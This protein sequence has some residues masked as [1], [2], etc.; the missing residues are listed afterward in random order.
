MPWLIGL[1]S[2]GYQIYQAEHAKSQAKKERQQAEESERGLE[3]SLNN[4]PKYRPN[5][6]ILNYY[7]E[8]LRKYNVAPTSTSEY[9]AEQQ[10]INRNAGSALRNLQ[11]RRSALAGVPSVM[12]V[13]NNAL[14][15]AA[16]KAEQ[17][18]EQQLNRVGQ[19][20]QMKASEE[21]K[22]FQQNEMYPF[23][24]KYN[25]LA[26]KAAGSRANQRINTQ[27]AYNL[28]SSLGALAS[29]QDNDE[30]GEAINKF[31]FGKRYGSN[32]AGAYNWAKSNNMNF[33]QYKRLGKKIGSAL[34]SGFGY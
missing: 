5:R 34:S 14:I 19:A 17:R 8:A 4:I 3:D 16:V 23:E 18:K 26:M 15:N 25:L 27:N 29:S 13:Q 21:G 24:S 7:D 31:R 11:D 9:K 1:A 32:A 2:T 28:F 10:F 30:F 12:S 20:A 33:G 6:S 22:A